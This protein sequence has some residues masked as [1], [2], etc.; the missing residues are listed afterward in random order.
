M[1]VGRPGA[2]VARA[3]A[4]HKIYIGRVWPIWPTKVRV[5]VGTQ[6]EMNKFAA[7]LTKVMA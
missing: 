2:E 4:T 6:E 7:A 5:S 1:E 3:M